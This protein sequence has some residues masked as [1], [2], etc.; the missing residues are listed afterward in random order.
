M[1]PHRL[2]RLSG[3]L[4]GPPSATANLL[5]WLVPDHPTVHRTSPA[6]T[7]GLLS[8]A[9]D[10][11][12]R[13]AFMGVVPGEYLLYASKPA[14][15][16]DQTAG[17][18]WSRITVGTADVQDVRI[19]LEPGA[20]ISGRVAFEGAATPP[21]DIIRRIIVSLRP[22]PGSLAAMRPAGGIPIG[23]DGSFQSHELAPGPYAMSVTPPAGWT[24][25]SIMAGS[26]DAAD[27][28]SN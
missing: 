5:I 3:Q 2:T 15:D 21:A 22:A 25:R 12:G 17:Y 19:A 24:L 18:A 11:E 28:R 14:S 9:A 13:F 10:P 16:A 7:I 20:R 26:H 1:R 4:N 8:S 23:P 6:T 27:R